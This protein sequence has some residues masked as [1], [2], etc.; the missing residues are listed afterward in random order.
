MSQRT[1]RAAIAAVVLAAAVAAAGYAAWNGWRGGRDPGA[2]TLYGNVDIREVELGF[3]VGGRVASMD[4]EEGERVHA[5]QRLATLDAQPYRDAL[6]S[7]EARVAQADAALAKLERGPRPQEIQQAQAAVREAQAAFTNA[8]REQTRQREL[9]QAGASSR[10]ALDAARARYEETAAR[11]A[12][13]REALAIAEEGSRA[14]DIAAAS[15]ELAAAVAQRDQAR[16]QLADTE[17]AAPSEGTILARIREPGAML[18]PGA[19]AY[20]LSLDAPVYVRAYAGE[21][22]LGTVVPG[23]EVLVTSD[24]SSRAYR[25]RIGFVSPRAEFTPRSVET[26]DLRTDLVYRLRIVITDADAGLRQGMP[27][28]VRVPREPEGG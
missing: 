28:T 15:A 4:V 26:T 23:A 2:F 5:G 14:E 22:D 12:N 25:G 27:V 10:R 11:L 18:A 24:S 16:T 9:E 8:D 19:A 3:R 6:A 7:A 20:T 13:A 21:R 1:T 17:L